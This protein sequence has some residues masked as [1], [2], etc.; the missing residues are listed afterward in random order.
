MGRARLLGKPRE[1][2]EKTRSAELKPSIRTETDTQIP[3]S[4]TED[5][6]N[7]KIS[8]DE[9]KSNKPDIEQF[10]EAD[11]IETK[12]DET[13]PNKPEIDQ[14]KF[15]AEIKTDET[16][17]EESKIEETTT[18]EVKPNDANNNEVKPVNI[19]FDKKLTVDSKKMFIDLI[20][21]LEDGSKIKKSKNN[22]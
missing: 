20:A 14:S 6:N 2:I 11:E 22:Y 18:D 17:Q 10:N 21:L 9:T 15:N 12:A 5:Q 1:N 16:K 19:E 4:N 3:R 7:N 13:K 8:K